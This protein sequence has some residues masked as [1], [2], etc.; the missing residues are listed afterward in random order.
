M[1]KYFH[2]DLQLSIQIKLKHWDL[3]LESFNQFVKKVI[4]A[5]GK[6]L[7]QLYTTAWELDQ[8]YF[9]GFWLAHT[10]KI[11]AS[12]PNSSMKSS[13]IEKLKVWMQEMTSS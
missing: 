11:K 12:T 13:R 8:H 1:L 3:E 7:L 10:T 2:K 9:R 5:K 6:V 4:E